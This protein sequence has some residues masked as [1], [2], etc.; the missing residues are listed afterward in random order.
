MKRSDVITRT[1]EAILGVER[2]VALLIGRIPTGE[3]D[4]QG[5]WWPSP[6]E[7]GKDLACRI[8]SPSRAFPNSLFRAAQTQRHTRV[9]ILRGIA[10]KPVPADVLRVIRQHFPAAVETPAS[11]TLSA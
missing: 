3:R 8:R 10:G 1:E 5:R 6:E 11:A 9:L 2:L 7:E 4:K